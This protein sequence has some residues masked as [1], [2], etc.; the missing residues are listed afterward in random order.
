MY[1]NLLIVGAGEFADIAY[2]YFT[3][4]SDAVYEIHIDTDEGNACGLGP[5][6]F[7]ELIK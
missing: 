1:K 2:E 7:C 6:T 3:M 5:S 4:D